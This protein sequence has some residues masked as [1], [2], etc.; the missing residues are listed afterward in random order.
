M[1][2]LLHRE[3]TEKII[4]AFYAVYNELGYGF[5]ESVYRAALIVELGRRGLAVRQ[6]VPVEV[7]YLGVSVGTFRIDLLVEDLVVVEIKATER[8]SH[9]DDKQVLNYLK[10]SS[11]EVGLLLHFGPEPLFHRFVSVNSRKKGHAVS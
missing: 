1:K 2:Q 7:L 11:V 9:A 10:A 5:L 8:T 3:L 4:G 6:E